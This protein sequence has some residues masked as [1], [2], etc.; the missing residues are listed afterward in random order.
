MGCGKTT[1]LEWFRARGVAV[2]ETDAC[3]RELLASDRELRGELRK[4]FG[5]EIFQSS[6]E[7][8]RARLG[9]IV[10][11]DPSGLALLEKLVHPRVRK[12][13][14][15]ELGKRHECLVVEIPLLFEKNLQSSF[16]LTCCVFTDAKVQMSRL[17]S[18]G[19]SAAHV[20]QRLARQWSSL[21][22]ARHA[23]VIL[24]NDGR[25]AHLETQLTRFC[26]RLGVRIAGS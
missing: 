5:E 14:T 13:W 22:K 18:R 26:R 17:R 2:F 15:A 21:E 11:A 7:V 16:D 1:V 24:L 20:A 9:A 10:F 12:A 19:W 3:V 6:G 23:D 4:A 8:D 25:R